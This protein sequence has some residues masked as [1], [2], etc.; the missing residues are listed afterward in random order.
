MVVISGFRLI[1][2]PRLAAG[3]AGEAVEF[4]RKHLQYSIIELN[5]CQPP[6]QRGQHPMITPLNALDIIPDGND[7]EA[8]EIRLIKL[9]P[10]KPFGNGTIQSAFAED[11]A[12]NKASVRFMDFDPLTQDWVGPWM[13]VSA[14]RNGKGDLTGLSV[15][16]YNNRKRINIKGTDQHGRSRVTID[17]LPGVPAAPAPAAAARQSGPPAHRNDIVYDNHPARPAMGPPPR[18][19]G[20]PPQAARQTQPPTQPP[21]QPSRPPVPAGP[22]GEAVGLA[23][24]LV[25]EPLLKNWAD[26]ESHLISSA[27]AFNDPEFWRACHR[28]CSEVLRLSEAL[29]GGD[30]A[31]SIVT[32]AVPDYPAE[33]AA[34]QEEPWPQD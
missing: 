26:A 29:K 5:C 31:P 13:R 21:A 19:A 30:I 20:P 32:A 22:P 17:W 8:V 6:K 34:A 7:L 28:G 3:M 15:D 1:H 11:A 16:S 24:K 4:A 9:D 23:I 2:L 25:L 14:T 12:G 18:Q 33:E 10:P 27:D